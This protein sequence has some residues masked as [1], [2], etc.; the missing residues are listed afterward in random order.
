MY[1]RGMSTPTDRGPARPAFLLAQLGSYAA[2]RFAERV[3]GLGVSPADAGIL[4]ILS[5]EDKLSQ[6]TLADRLG[7]VPSRVVVLIDS[8]ERRGLVERARSATDRR[9]YELSLTGAGRDILKAIGPLAREHQDELLAPLSAEERE[10]F[11]GLLVLL[12]EAHGLD[13]EVHRGYRG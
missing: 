9:N 6:K 11:T 2:G 3:N 8:L 12:A 10:T 4:R 1:Y 5:R 13:Q 7:A